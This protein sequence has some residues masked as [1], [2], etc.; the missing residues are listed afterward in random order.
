MSRGTQ[1]E[2]GAC[3]PSA[4]HESSAAGAHAPISHVAL[5]GSV[6]R[7]QICDTQMPNLSV[8][9]PLTPSCHLKHTSFGSPRSIFS[10]PRRWPQV[11]SLYA[12][13]PS[14]ST[15]HSPQDETQMSKNV[16]NSDTKTPT[17]TQAS[18]QAKTLDASAAAQPARQHRQ[19][20]PVIGF[21]FRT[22]LALS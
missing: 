11:W 6:T 14:S 15:Q 22:F 3:E 18:M 21:S 19:Q 20:L 1:G 13:A 16:E 4:R 5:M 7:P 12:G 9:R 2:A 8:H 17:G 10:Q